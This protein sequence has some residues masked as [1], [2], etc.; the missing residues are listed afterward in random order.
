MDDELVAALMES[1]PADSSSGRE[2]LRRRLGPQ[3]LVLPIV[4][5]CELGDRVGDADGRDRWL[6]KMDAQAAVL[7]ADWIAHLPERRVLVLEQASCLYAVDD[8]TG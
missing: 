2:E 1:L 6:R 8:K 7:L 4:A 3:E 5:H